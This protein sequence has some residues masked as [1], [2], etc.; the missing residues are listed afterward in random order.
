MDIMDNIREFL[1]DLG[2]FALTVLQAVVYLTVGFAIL[3]ACFGSMIYA[4]WYFMQ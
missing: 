1:Y 3:G 4:V 2:Y